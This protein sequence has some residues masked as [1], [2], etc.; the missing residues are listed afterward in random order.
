[1]SADAHLNEQ[2]FFHGTNVAL[3][4]GAHISPGHK[5][6][7]M[8]TPDGYV[9]ASA[10]QGFAEHYAHN[11]VAAHGGEPHTYAVE[12][13]GPA[14]RDPMLDRDEPDHQSMRSPHP[15]RVVREVR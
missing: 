15:L 12:F 6:A 14:E 9:Y 1:M 2:Q 13:S 11:A 10:Y 3:P 7:T 8:G 4:E 5:S